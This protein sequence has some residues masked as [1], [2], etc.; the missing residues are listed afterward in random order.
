MRSDFPLVLIRG[1]GDLAS[2]VAI[3]LH[4]SGFPVVMT[5]IERPLAVRRTVAFAQAVFDGVCQ[6]EEVTGRRCLIEEAPAVIARDEIAVV[7][8]PHGEAIRHLQP[9]VVVDAIMAK[10]NTGTT[11][12]D[13][14]LVVALGPGF[15]AGVDCHAVIE[16]ER[17]HNLGRV[18]WQ[19]NAAPDTGEPGELP[20]IGRRA[21]RVLRA[22]AAGHVIGRYVIGDRV[23][24]GVELAVVQ[25]E[26]GAAHSILAPFAGVLRGLIHPSVRVHAGMKIGDLDPRADVSYCFTVS[27]KS[28]AIGGGALEAILMWLAQ[29]QKERL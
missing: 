23:A 21:S 19:G 16:T 27:D 26:T 3:R 25:D 28:L 1:A 10:R 22:P 18:I 6:V 5:E 24:E 14:P 13:A 4:R 29:R 2:G 20:G 7:V 9:S 8:D 17:G 15:T 12:Q 11:L